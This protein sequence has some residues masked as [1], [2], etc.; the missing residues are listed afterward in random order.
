MMM[1]HPH[2]PAWGMVWLL[3]A[4]LTA[5]ACRSSY[6]ICEIS[7]GRIAVTS[8]FDTAPCPEAVA[9]L[10]PYKAKVDS[11]MTP[12]IGQS[13][14]EMHARR[15]ESLLSNLAADILK[16]AAESYTGRSVDLAITNMGGLRNSLPAGPIAFGNIYEIFPFQNSLCI[17][18]MK[19]EVLLRLFT[20][21]AAL[22]GECVSHGVKLRVSSTGRLLQATLR[23][24]PVDPERTY[25]VASIDYLAEGN[26]GLTAFTQATSKE[27]P[28]GLTIRQLVVDYVKSLAAKGEPVRSQL[29]GR[30]I[31]EQP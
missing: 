26:D 20:Q 10:A 5:T 22:G 16:Q 13:A 31:L 18:Q 24:E 28:E 17:M 12:I 15:P 8:A 29:E 14:Q 23:D 19:G 9:I 7:G 30:I 25:T 2:A 11:V 21:I 4:A 6:Q 1:K 27:C 3:A